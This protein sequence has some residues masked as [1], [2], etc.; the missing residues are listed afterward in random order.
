MASKPESRLQLNIK[1][2][3]KRTFKKSFWFKV[4]GGP[5]QEAGIPDLIG[6]VRGKFIG[7][8]VKCPEGKPATELQEEQM[9]QIRDA[10]GAATVVTSEE[11]AVNAVF[12][13][14]GISKTNR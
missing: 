5:Y 10:K 3:L 13:S 4:H 7:L 2:R 9:Q 14:L 6:C 12:R 11:E 8:E 1:K